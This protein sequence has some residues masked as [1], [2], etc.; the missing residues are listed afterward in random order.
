MA[1]KDKNAPA[2]FG[3]PQVTAGVS[4]DPAAAKY[5]RQSVAARPPLPPPA[6][7]AQ[8]VGGVPAPPIP[9][10]T[11]SPT[12]A[13]L[14]MADYAARRVP[15]S[16]AQQAVLGV[17][18]AAGAPPSF[19]QPASPTAPRAPPWADQ[20]PPLVQPAPTAPPRPM[21]QGLL[22]GDTLPERAK[23]DPQY[24]HGLGSDMAM[25]QPAMAYK[26]GVVRNGRHIAPQQLNSGRPGLRPETK[27]GIAA[28][29]REMEQAHAERQPPPDE[30]A[31]AAASR[32]GAAPEGGEPSEAK[33][34]AL[35]T[36]DDWDFMKLRAVMSDILSNDNQRVIVEERLEPLSLDDLLM[37]GWVT[38][39]VPI[40]VDPVTK[41]KKFFPTFRT[42]TAQ[43]DNLLKL[44][45]MKEVRALELRGAYFDEK[46]AMMAACASTLE[47]NGRP[48][49]EYLD[50]YGKFD[51]EKFWEKFNKFVLLPVHTVSSLGVHAFW[52]DMRV[53]Q[54]HVAERIKNG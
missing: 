30:R 47:I 32:L 39:E 33:K 48:L 49:P 51:E 22:M 35:E 3:P 44:L 21:T 23:S 53:R 27:E 15:L 38:Q 45:L 42:V 9:P 11:G 20:P 19:V 8:P 25:N 24:Q 14:V 46:F 54:L 31:A 34:S 26:Y 6:E 5:M 29:V 28:V 7:H 52:F 17:G 1:L 10:L 36:L 50:A 43:T 4:V 41:Q 16:P 40:V 12:D 13:G 18:A 2:H 37:Q